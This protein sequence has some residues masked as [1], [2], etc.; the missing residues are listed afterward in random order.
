[1]DYVVYEDKPRTDIWLKLI[2][3]L[4]SILLLI[5]ALIFSK[6]DPAGTLYFVYGAAGTALI[7]AVLYVL[8]LPTR[9]CV[10][11][12]KMKIEFRGPFSFSIPFDTVAGVRDARWSTV[13]I[14]FPTNMS[15][16]AVLEIVRKGRMAVTITPSDKQAFIQSFH[17]A[18][19]DWKQGKDS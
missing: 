1:M 8:L 2:F 18:F 3:M 4:P 7:M 17:K 14:N 16:S 5:S 15:Q 10:L 13:G 6:T 9:Y 19:E 12:N 11:N